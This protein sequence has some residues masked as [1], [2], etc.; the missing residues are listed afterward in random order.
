MVTLKKD[1]GTMEAFKKNV[2][3]MGFIIGIWRQEIEDVVLSPDFGKLSR[4]ELEELIIPN[5]RALK[6]WTTQL[7]TYMDKVLSVWKNRAGQRD[8]K[9]LQYTLEEA[10]AE[11]AYIPAGMERPEI[12]K[13]S[14]EPAVKVPVTIT[15]PEKVEAS[16]VQ[17]D[18]DELLQ[19]MIKGKS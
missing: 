7:D 11:F 3:S 19:S 9:L 18:E 8:S 13:A 15:V 17:S 2:E 10:I 4:E 14:E 12:P 16:I 1:F 6:F 5:A